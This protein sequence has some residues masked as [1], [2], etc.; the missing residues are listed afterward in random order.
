M[1]KW[2]ETTEKKKNLKKN[3]NKREKKAD[4]QEIWRIGNNITGAEM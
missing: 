3:Q 2:I 4:V 1:R